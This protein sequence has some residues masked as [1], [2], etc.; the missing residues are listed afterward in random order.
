MPVNEILAPFYMRVSYQTWASVHNVT[1]YL[2]S[3]TI[4]PSG[5]DFLH[6]AAVSPSNSTGSLQNYVKQVFDIFYGSIGILAPSI[7][8]IDLFQSVPSSPNIYLGPILK[9]SLIA[10]ATKGV[11]AS[12]IML[13]GTSVSA[14]TRQNWRL[15]FFESVTGTNPQRFVEDW[16]QTTSLFYPLYLNAQQ[17]LMVT[18]DGYTP[19][20]RSYNIGYNRKLARRYGRLL[21]P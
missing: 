8:S 17:G 12:Y 14:S 1:L 10:G 4:T 9:P 3:G 21:T 6:S 2:G 16:S 13:S 11:A 20:L 7:L 5:Q 15:M 18:Q 19:I